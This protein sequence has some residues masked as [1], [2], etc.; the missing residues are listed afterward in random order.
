MPRITRKTGPK[1][2]SKSEEKNKKSVEKIS[3]KKS[4]ES[5]KKLKV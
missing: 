4:N 5:Q 2:D 3:T 1:E